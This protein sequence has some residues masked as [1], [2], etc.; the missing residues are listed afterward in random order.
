MADIGASIRDLRKRHN[1]KQEEL[2]ALLHVT[3]QT[4]SNYENGRSRPD[5]DTL[6]RIAE[7]FRTDV[8][9]L[10]DMK[11]PSCT[12]QSPS[13]AVKRL[14]PPIILLVL[15]WL[16]MIVSEYSVYLIQY[17]HPYAGWNTVNT[18]CLHLEPLLYTALGY[19]AAKYLSLLLPDGFNRLKKQ[20]I[21]RILTGVLLFYFVL[22][23]HEL[24]CAIYTDILYYQHLSLP[25]PRSF[26][27]PEPLI[28]AFSRV[29][30]SIMLYSRVYE[31]LSVPC[32][33]L[34]GMAISLTKKTEVT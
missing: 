12:T 27:S 33:I 13:K 2:A 31:A 26:V 24:I 15:V 8:N 30:I 18:L 6:V 22:L 23:F 19:L 16:V 7:I 28:P 14:L 32:F 10:L 29:L 20:W 3:R 5:L 17:K 4:V 21:H 11:L 34:Y 1:M 25:P 9:T